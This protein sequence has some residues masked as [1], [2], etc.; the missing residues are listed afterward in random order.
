MSQHPRLFMGA[1]LILLTLAA[2]LLLRPTANGEAI[3]INDTAVPPA[4]TL[5]PGRVARGAPL[6]AQHCAACHGANLEGA[7]DWKRPLAGGSYPPPP[8]DSSGHT[9]H[10]TDAL[11]LTII[12]EGGQSVVVDPAYKSQ[13]PAFADKL[14][15]ED[16]IA[17][18]EF[19]KDKWEKEK[20]EFQWWV[21]YTRGNEP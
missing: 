18:L 13:M 16:M 21:T 10:H 2:M 3:V 17:V 9:W 4:P 8:H 12:A 5:D 11:L 7:P 15:D 6:Y 20:R 14:S 1:V 19:I